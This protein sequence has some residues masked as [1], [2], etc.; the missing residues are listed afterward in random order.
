MSKLCTKQ[1][2]D[3]FT[4]LLSCTYMVSYITRTNFGAIISE[5][6]S[7]TGIS[8]DLLSIALVG[9]FITYGSGQVVS[10]I[11]GDH[12]SPKRLVSLGLVITILMNISLPLCTSY[13]LMILVW[14]INGFAQSFMWPPLV[15]MMSAMLSE[16][17]YKQA[18]TRVSWGSSVGTILVYLV[19]PW[20]ISIASWKWVFMASA[21]AGIC[22]LVI[23]NQYAE[24][25]SISS[26]GNQKS[27]GSLSLSPLMISIMLAII[28]QGMLRDGVTTWMPS[29]IAETYHLSNSTSILTGVVLPLFSILCFSLATKLYTHV[30]RNP[31]V[32]AGTFF[33]VGTLSS[34]TLYSFNDQ[35]AV[36]SVI[37]SAVLTGCM[38]G[39]NLMLV[40]MLPAYFSKYGNVGTV[41]GVLNSC[42]YVGSAVSTYGIAVISQSLGWH[43]TIF[44]WFMIALLG[45]ILCLGSA[46]QWYQQYME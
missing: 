4:I 26:R 8:R 31:L 37:C 39:V 18:T 44:V 6:V 7:A 2:V 13:L 25:I 34:I 24:E 29:Y 45:T 11:L 3:L 36:L 41:S 20:I 17:D 40:C 12:I 5:V 27:K 15:R 35:S 32:C 42:T 10:G 33:L 46:K 1:Q 9:S 14:C 22:M 16:E 21:C 19:A 28:L 30:L 43:S 23:W 38:Q